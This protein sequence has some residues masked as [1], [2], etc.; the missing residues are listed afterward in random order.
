MRNWLAKVLS[1]VI[2]LFIFIFHR[3][4]LLETKVLTVPLTQRSSVE[5]VIA[6]QIPDTVRI[7]LRGEKDAI[8]PITENDIEAYIDLSGYAAKGSYRPIIQI[9][10]LGNALDADPLE[11]D[12]KPLDIFVQLDTKASKVLPISPDISGTVAS[13]YE[14]V[15]KT[16]NPDKILIEGPSSVVDKMASVLTER[17]DLG[18]RNSDFTK[19][20]KLITSNS[21]ITING[22]N[23]AEFHASI[24]SIS[25]AKDFEESPIGIKNLKEGFTATL[26]HKTAHIRLQGPM[27]DIEHIASEVDDGVEYIASVDCRELQS[28]GTYTLP[29][30]I[31]IP[32]SIETL[33]F[34]PE[35]I[36]VEI[37]IGQ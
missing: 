23:D 37:Q 31:N 33:S 35:T 1:L 10:K 8:S 14:L 29:V 13:G 22:S 20:V 19:V 3:V 12:P 16:V 25:I 27:N 30:K 7:T 2:A 24:K 5:F 28:A 32:E 6:N 18:E 34:D 15:S 21:A 26:S 11:I 36:Q 17:I 4:N 9:I